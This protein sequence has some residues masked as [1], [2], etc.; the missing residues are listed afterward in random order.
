M[1]IK[2]PIPIKKIGDPY[3]LY[4]NDKYYLYATC[5]FNGYYCWVSEDLRQWSEP[6]IC[7]EATDKSF[8]NSCFWAPEVY[9]FEGKFYMYYTAHWKKF[10]DEAL[11]IGIAVANHP[12]GPFEDVLD[13]KPM[14]DFGYGVLD[15]NILKDGENNYLYYSRAGADHFVNGNKEAEIYVVKLGKDY[16]SV[17]GEGKLILRAEQEWERQNP[18][19]KQFWNEGPFVIKHEG[20]YHMMYSANFYASKYYGIG[21]AVAD[22]PM[23]P[24]EKYGDNP[25]LSTNDVI[26]GPGHNSVVQGL[27]GQYYCV[28]HAHTDYNHPSGDRQV[29]IAP[30]W[31]EN[32]RIY[33]QHPTT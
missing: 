12:E 6:K 17:E 3:V 33:V 30:L 19:G 9:E 29:Y 20:R 5:H 2:N 22:H 27:N 28:Y 11:R 15:A 13:E 1:N 16:I 31:F 21:G 7:Y 14:F 23:G 25:I 10:K 32:D 18:E 8:G 4:F 24:F 26:S